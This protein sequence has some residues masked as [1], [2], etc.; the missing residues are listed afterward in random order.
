MQLLGTAGSPGQ[1][2]HWCRPPAPLAP[3]P[4]LRLCS[5]GTLQTHK[6]SA[7]S[8][9]CSHV[10][11]RC[12]ADMR[13]RRGAARAVLRHQ[14]AQPSAAGRDRGGCQSVSSTQGGPCRACSCSQPFQAAG[15]AG[16]HPAAG[17]HLPAGGTGDPGASRQPGQPRQRCGPGWKWAG[18]R[19]WP[20]E[21][22]C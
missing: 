21:Q 2:P 3:A 19:R 10:H 16:C 13:R 18:S 1:E 4:A 22:G 15:P 9:H 7:P 11:S 14:A 20:S 17:W 12:C 5:H 8:T 6:S